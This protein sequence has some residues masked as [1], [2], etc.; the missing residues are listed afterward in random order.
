LPRV[1]ELDYSADTAARFATLTNRPWAVFLDSGRR[2]GAGARYDIYAAEPYRTITTRGEETVV[3]GRDAQR[4]TKGDPLE[5]LREALGAPDRGPGELPFGGGAIGYFGYDL[6][7]R[8]EKLP[9]CAEPDIDLPELA[10]GIYDWAVIVDHDRCRSWLVGYGKDERTFDEWSEIRELVSTRN[11]PFEPHFRVVSPVRSNLDRSEYEA[12]FAAVKA[13]IERGDC[14]QVNLTQ[15]FEALTEGDS[16]GAYLRLRDVSPAP[17]SAFLRYPFGD[18]LSSSPE[19]FLK[20]CGSRV[21]TRPIKGTRPRRVS[22]S[23]DRAL[24]RELRSSAKDRAENVMIVD[25]LRNDL[26]RTCTP[27]SIR[28]TRL[29]DI[30]SFANVHHLVSTIEGEIAPDRD[31]LDVLRACFPGGSITGAPK[32][33]AMEIIEGLEPHRRSVYCGAIGYV[34]FDRQ[35]DTNIAIRTLVHARGSIYAWAGG[36]IVADSDVDAEY[37]ESLDKASGLLAVLDAA[38]IAS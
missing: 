19:R 3:D 1:E 21:E 16:W 24:A 2:R 30:E 38:A 29:F 14:Y 20:V 6:G 35:M 9:V 23:Q 25:L 8:Y 4:A 18:I 36:G 11:R 10:V 17:Y 33:R 32:I 7:R 27:G 31:P 28:A 37:Q 15:R 34:G 22:A 26:G 12:A 5:V 13:H